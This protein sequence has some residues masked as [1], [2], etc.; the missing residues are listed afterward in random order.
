VVASND[1]PNLRLVTI[2]ASYGAGG[3]VV[4]PLL[5]ERLGLPFADR[6]LPGPG[7]PRS[8]SEREVTER[9]LEKVPRSSLLESLALVSSD[10]GVP[11]QRGPGDLPGHVQAEVEASLREL[12]ET[13]GGVVLGRAAAVPLAGHPRVFHVRLDGPPERRA[14]RGALWEGV[15]LATATAQLRETDA[16]RARYV[17]RLYRRD[18]ADPALYHLILDSTLMAADHTVE[19]VAA[20]AEA[21]WSYDE[22]RLAPDVERARARQ[23]SQRTRQTRP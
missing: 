23:A 17:K 6:L 19:V 2:S 14:R 5:A 8:P 21:F 7:G 9:E 18:P 22:A 12:L 1:A 13:G 16:A 10:W 15:D 20:A 4:A 3:S 11:G